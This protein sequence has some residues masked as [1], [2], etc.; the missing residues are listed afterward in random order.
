MAARG[1]LTAMDQGTIAGRGMAVLPR[2][3]ARSTPPCPR[4]RYWSPTIC[5]VSTRAMDWLH[6]RAAEARE[7]RAVVKNRSVRSVR[8]SSFSFTGSSRPAPLRMPEE[9]QEKS[10]MSMPFTMD[11]TPP[12]D[13]MEASSGWSSSQPNTLIW[14]ASSHPTP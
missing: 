6:S 2:A 3:W 11:T 4:R 8:C 14:R 5:S 13:R 9:V 10:T 7:T 1:T 12:P